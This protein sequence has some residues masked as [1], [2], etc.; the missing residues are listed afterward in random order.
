MVDAFFHCTPAQVMASSMPA[1]DRG[2]KP[3][4]AGILGLELFERFAVTLD[5]HAKTMTLTPL[6]AFTRKPHGV[7]L[8]IRFTEDAPTTPGTFN[9]LPGDFELDS[10]DAGPAIIEGYWADQRGLGPQ[11]SRG[12]VWSGG[13]VGGDYQ[14]TLSRGDIALGPIN[15]PHEIVSYVGQPVRGSESTRMQ[16]GLVGES[17]LY[18]F[19][20]TYDYGHRLVWIDPHTGIAPRAFNRA[21]LRLKKDKAGGLEV[22][23]VVPNSPAAEAGIAVGDR[24]LNIADRPAGALAPSDTLVLLSGP[25]DSVVTLSVAAGANHQARS[26]NLKLRELLP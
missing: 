24:V 6:E 15:L 12:I 23:L 7:A 18:R 10:G 3:P 5:R 8:P 16:A 20:M 22:T 17:S 25:V 4:R 13:G 9:G 14:E 21:G 26:V 19:D 1:N 2:A 11:L